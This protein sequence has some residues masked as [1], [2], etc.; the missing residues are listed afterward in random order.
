MANS[1]CGKRKLAVSFIPCGIPSDSIVENRVDTA[2]TF[3]QSFN[4]CSSSKLICS[5]SIAYMSCRP[6]RYCVNGGCRPIMR[7]TAKQ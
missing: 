2:Q 6:I 4:V 5:L 7:L 3:D 1:L